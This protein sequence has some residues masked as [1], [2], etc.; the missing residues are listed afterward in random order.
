MPVPTSDNPCHKRG[1]WYLTGNVIIRLGAKTKCFMLKTIDDMEIVNIEARTFEAMTARF[2][3]FVQ[4]INSLC[5]S[6]DK[7]LTKW[8]D[9]QEVCLI[10]H[11][12]KRTLQT[13]RD[14]GTLP[15][16]QIN[17]K[18]YYKLEDVERVMQYA[19]Q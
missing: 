4:R 13:Y 1:I 2:E 18:M 8:L 15:Y 17:H 5:S 16:S 10:L 6:R 19:K 7:G 14:N 12:S 9:N 11:I 3:Q